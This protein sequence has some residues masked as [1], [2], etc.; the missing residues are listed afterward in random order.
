MRNLGVYESL[1]CSDLAHLSTIFNVR[2]LNDA[3]SDTDLFRRYLRLPEQE[4][5]RKSSKRYVDGKLSTSLFEQMLD[6]NSMERI[7]KDEISKCTS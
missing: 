4:T 7:E 1:V 2:F 5:V 6:E 3:I